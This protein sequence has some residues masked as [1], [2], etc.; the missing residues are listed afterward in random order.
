MFAFIYCICMH[1]N[2]YLEKLNS[3]HSFVWK[4]NVIVCLPLMSHSRN[5]ESLE[6]N[7]EF[8]WQSIALYNFFAQGK[9]NKY[10]VDSISKWIFV[11]PIVSISTQ[12][13]VN[14]LIFVRSKNFQIIIIVELFEAQPTSCY[15]VPTY[16]SCQMNESTIIKAWRI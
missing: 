14:T 2:F 15:N 16:F 9:T 10:T 1:M 3:F 5:F 12:L 11:L 7:V 13:K 8:K 6:L 4:V